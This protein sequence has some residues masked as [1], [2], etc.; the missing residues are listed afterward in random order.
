MPGPAV[1]HHIVEHVF[2]PA[3]NAAHR[4]A[5]N[6]GIVGALFVSGLGL[7]L[8]EDVPL[9]AAGFTTFKQAGDTFVLWRY[10]LT[11]VMVV[12]P[13]LLG[14][15]CAWGM[16]RKF[17]LPLRDRVKYLRRILDDK[18]VARVQRWFASYGG[19]AIFLGRQ[20]AG[21]RFVTF[22]MAGV[23]KVSLPRFVFWD[24][25]GCVVSVPIWLTLGTL[26]ARYGK[27]W[28]H[29]A[30]RTVGSTFLIVV[31]SAVVILIV[32]SKIRSAR[33]AAAQS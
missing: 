31:F 4:A 33:R 28:L 7:P 30:S 10:V 16:G 21:V 6:G 9:S 27:H 32:V 14:D 19:A 1:F 23:M 13:I 26:A 24:F 2:D 5:I 3:W 29:A 12:T 22:Y 17:G 25:M 8:P 20:V 18:R 11:F 15:I